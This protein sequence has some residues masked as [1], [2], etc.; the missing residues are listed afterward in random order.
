MT[1]EEA[2]G[3]VGQEEVQEEQQEMQEIQQES[4]HTEEV[5]S[6]QEIQEVQGLTLD[7]SGHLSGVQI[8]VMEESPLVPNS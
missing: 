7:A 1:V 8:V 2:E 5:Q 6:H 3:R 4:M